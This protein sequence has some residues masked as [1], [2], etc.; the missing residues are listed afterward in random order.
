MKKKTYLDQNIPSGK[1]IVKTVYLKGQNPRNLKGESAVAAILPSHM[2]GIASV[3]PNIFPA[4]PAKYFRLAQGF[5]TCGPRATC[6][7]R[8]NTVWPA[9]SY[10][11]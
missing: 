3:P 8:G 5:P 7:P 2:E 1:Q 4:T 10:T 6:G 9:N 11:F